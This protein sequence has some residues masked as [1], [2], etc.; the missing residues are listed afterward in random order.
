MTCAFRRVFDGAAALVGD[1]GAGQFG[2]AGVDGAVE[3]GDGDALAGVALF[4]CSVE[5]VVG[6]VLLGCNGVGRVSGGRGQGEGTDSQCERR[7][8]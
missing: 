3:E 6:E 4:T 8:R 1:I 5:A 2:G 7:R